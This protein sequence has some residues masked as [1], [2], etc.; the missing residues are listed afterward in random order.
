MDFPIFIFPYAKPLDFNIQSK[1]LE[2]SQIFLDQ[3]NTHGAPLNA[4]AWISENQFL[5]FEVDP[6]LNAPSGCSKDKLYHFVEKSNINLGIL[7]G[8]AHKFYLKTGAEIEIFDKAALK[9]K[10]S[11]NALFQDYA[12]F[13]IWFSSKNEFELLWG[14]P[15]NRFAQLLRLVERI[16]IFNP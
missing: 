11:N 9:E 15:L 1:L 16:A 14:K 5:I 7:A 2:F 4:R 13:P 8:D 6:I 10:W 12:L 3:W